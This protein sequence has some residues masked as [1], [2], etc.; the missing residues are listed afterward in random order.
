MSNGYSK[1]FLILGNFCEVTYKMGRLIWH[2]KGQNQSTPNRS[3]LFV[4]EDRSLGTG[5]QKK[6]SG[7]HEDESDS[8]ECDE[9]EYRWPRIETP[10]NSEKHEQPWRA[11]SLNYSNL[12]KPSKYIFIIYLYYKRLKISF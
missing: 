2:G 5:K 4:E 3:L 11:D 1:L 7:L 9:E 12:S 8:S 10:P 6:Y